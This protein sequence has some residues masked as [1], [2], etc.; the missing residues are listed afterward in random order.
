MSVELNG[1]GNASKFSFFF[2]HLIEWFESNH[3]VISNNS[4][5]DME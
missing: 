1:I 4:S 2:L 3:E 5:D